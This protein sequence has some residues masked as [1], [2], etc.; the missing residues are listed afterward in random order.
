MKVRI[1]FQLNRRF[2]VIEKLVFRLVLNGFSNA[3]EI[4]LSLPLFSDAVIANAV[5]RLVNEQLIS[6]DVETGTL[7]LSEAVV[8][9]I[10]MCQKQSFEIDIPASLEDVIL[11]DGIV[12][13]D[14]RIPEVV[15]LK[16]TIIQELLPN[17][18]LDQYRYSLD[19]IIL[20][21]GGEANE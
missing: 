17:V 6:A 15:W 18:K 16:D 19:F 12:V 3:R 5:R 14:N 1:D 11:Q 13:F 21:R 4:K 7:S 20:P 9:I 8:A 2:G 10:A